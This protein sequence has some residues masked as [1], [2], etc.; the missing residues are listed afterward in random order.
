VLSTQPPVPGTKNNS[1]WFAALLL[2]PLL[3]LRRVRRRLARLPRMTAVLLLATSCGTL[4]LAGCSGGYYGPQPH[5]YV[6][7]ITGQ[8]GTT[9]NTTTVSLTIQ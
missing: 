1:P 2:L 8:S 9:L 6:L 7:T 3:G 4:A 5:T